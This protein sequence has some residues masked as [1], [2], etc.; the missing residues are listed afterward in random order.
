MIEQVRAESLWTSQKL[1]EPNGIVLSQRAGDVP[2]RPANFR[3]N[4][5]FLSRLWR[6]SCFCHCSS[7]TGYN[8]WPMKLDALTPEIWGLDVVD[9]AEPQG[10]WRQF[11]FSVR[12]A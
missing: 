2:S 11:A 4:D 7:Q 1:G 3:H 12:E 5:S 6:F 8:S 9:D 10:L